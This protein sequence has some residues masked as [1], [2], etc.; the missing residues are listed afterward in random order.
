MKKAP[1]GV[2]AL[3]DSSALENKNLSYLTCD[4][5]QF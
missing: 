1:T 2:G 5:L 4:T 3:V